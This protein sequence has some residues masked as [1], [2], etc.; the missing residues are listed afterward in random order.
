MYECVEVSTRDEDLVFGQAPGKWRLFRLVQDELG[1]S[2]QEQCQVSYN[3]MQNNSRV[4]KKLIMM[5]GK[6]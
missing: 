1:N 3:L 6:V 4:Q 2:R 5:Q